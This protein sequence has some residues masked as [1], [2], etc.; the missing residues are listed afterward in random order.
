MASA[1]AH[2]VGTPDRPAAAPP[3]VPADARPR[4]G[5]GWRYPLAVALASRVLVLVVVGVVGWWQRPD[6]APLSDV[7]LRPLGAW[8]GQWYARIAEHG[9][10][11]TIAHGNAAAFFPLYPS[12]VGAVHAA[13]PFVPVQAIGVVLSNGFFVAA[14]LVLWQLT[15]RRLGEAVARRVVWYVAL[16]PLAFVFSAVYTESLFLLL[17]VF[18]FLLMERGQTGWACAVAALAV[19]TRPVGIVLGPALAWRLWT[20]NG[21]R[22]DRVLARRA[23]PLLLLPLA[24]AGF[25]A[26]L[27]W[28]TGLPGAT[29]LAQERGWGREA[30]PLLVLLLP[31]A[32]VLGVAQAIGGPH[33]LQELIDPV[34]AS[35][36]A[37]LVLHAAWR[38][39]LPGEYLLAAAGVLILPALAGTYLAYPRYGLTIFVLAW[40]LALHARTRCIDLALRAGGVLAMVVLAVLTYGTGTYT[41]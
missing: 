32:A 8:D 39:L 25:Q 41:P 11:P 34:V 20:D 33:D 15:R 16:A 1:V 2:R 35:A 4:E 19:L 17:V 29:E 23:L 7:L 21:R 28:Q 30:D 5:G 24:Y 27:W 26:Y 14:V 31:V 37:L 12:L 22:F 6:G 38:R 40:L 13:L 18:A 3:S 36:M 9:Y 10:D